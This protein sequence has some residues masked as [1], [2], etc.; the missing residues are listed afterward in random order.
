M[1]ER[2]LVPLAPYALLALAAVAG[3]FIF[4]SVEREI[5]R[6]KSRLEPL[7]NTELA[8]QH[9]LQIQLD[10]LSARLREAEERSSAPIQAQPATSG[11]NLNKRNQ[12]I[13]M[14]RRGQPAANIA[15]SL[16]MSRREVELLL[17][18][19]ALSLSKLSEKAS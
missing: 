11:V 17:K 7:K 18:I 4:I 9:E 6:L 3:L 16:S 13:R 1:L 8:G 2:Y 15:A 14:S 19:H 5:R 10:D 12:V